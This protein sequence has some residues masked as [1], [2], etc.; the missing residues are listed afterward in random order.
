[1]GLLVLRKE[2]LP[3]HAAMPV[4]LLWIGL[5]AGASGLRGESLERETADAAK[6]TSSRAAREDSQRA[7]PFSRLD[8]RGQAKVQ[9]V[10]ENVSL[11]RRLPVQ[12]TQCD[13]EMYDFLIRHPDVVVNIWQ[14]LGVSK[15]EAEQVGD[16]IYRVADHAGTTGRIEFLY[17]NRDTQL[18]YCEGVY[19][20]PLFG[21][22]VRGKVLI[23]LKT[24][25]VQESDGRYYITSRMDAFMNVQNLGLD[26]LTK[27]F[28]PM[29]ARSADLNFVQTTSFLGSL[30]RTA[31]VNRSG[32]QRLASKLQQVTPEVRQEFAQ[33]SNR[34]AER[35]V[36]LA[37]QQANEPVPLSH[38]P[39]R[40]GAD[41]EPQVAVRPRN[42]AR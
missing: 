14:V 19:E 18:V 25:Y 42:S 20:G 38:A 27:T 7:I 1:M 22:D 41:T 9:S 23:L 15:V 5:A 33:L 37:E 26:I 12:V 30:S 28:Q 39:S 35:A 13:P 11:F 31:E 32:M 34:V 3:R 16:G 36:V 17:T 40:L 10:L 4:L 21:R 8:A 2:H 24:G 6:A 29:V